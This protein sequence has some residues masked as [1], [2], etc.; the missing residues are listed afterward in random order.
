M[1]KSIVAAR[2]EQEITSTLQVAEIIKQANP[3]WEKHKHPATR[4]FQGIRIFINNELKDLQHALAAILELLAVGGR[5]VVI[6]FH[7]LEDRIV[8]QFIQKQVRGDDYPPGVPVT[9]DQL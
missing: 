4:A 6:S 5:L 3:A 1:A 2:Q 7:S 9:Q 8:K